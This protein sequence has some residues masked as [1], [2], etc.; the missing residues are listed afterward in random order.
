MF[1]DLGLKDEEGF[2]EDE[3]YRV[4]K[5]LVQDSAL[6]IKVQHHFRE[7]LQ[8]TSIRYDSRNVSD[9]KKKAD[10]EDVMRHMFLGYKKEYMVSKEDYVT[11]KTVTVNGGYS[12]LYALDIALQA[13]WSIH[14]VLEGDTLYD[15]LVLRER[16]WGE[17]AYKAEIIKVENTP[18][19][20][21]EGEMPHKLVVYAVDR[22]AGNRAVMTYKQIA[23]LTAIRIT[24]IGRHGIVPGGVV[25]GNFHQ[26]IF[27]SVDRADLCMLNHDQQHQAA[28]LCPLERFAQADFS[29]KRSIAV[30][31]NGD[32]AKGTDIVVTSKEG[33]KLLSIAPQDLVLVVPTTM[34]IEPNRSSIIMY[35]PV[36]WHD[37]HHFNEWLQTTS[38]G[39]SVLEQALGRKIG[40]LKNMGGSG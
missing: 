23:A 1:R 29:L 26:K 27:G 22:G 2:K 21:S 12:F 19:C 20:K 3:V 10:A 7:F 25:G 14:N 15:P 34:Q 32:K 6:V 9:E 17:S 35:D 8:A 16:I 31:V 30:M 18:A 24:S 38:A 11:D 36:H 39:I 37:F 5:T 28:V 4:I 40:D 33:G 13:G